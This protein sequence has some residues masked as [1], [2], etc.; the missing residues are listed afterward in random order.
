MVDSAVESGGGRAAVRG[1][2]G[3]VLGFCV[4][5]LDCFRDG[6]MVVTE[7]A[8]ANELNLLVLLSGALCLMLLSSLSCSKKNRIISVG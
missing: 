7:D 1:W 6:R 2:F 3:I 8:V 5:F 4:R